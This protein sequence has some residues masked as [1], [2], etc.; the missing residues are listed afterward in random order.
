MPETS[1]ET[2]IIPDLLDVIEPV[3]AVIT[4]DAMGTQKEVERT[5]REHHAD[6][7]FALK[8]NHPTLLEDVTWAFTHADDL[9]WQGIEH[10]YVRTIEKG[11]GRLETRECRVVY[12]LGTLDPRWVAAWP[13]L[14][15]VARVRGH[16]EVNGAES[17]EDRYLLTSLPMNRGSTHGHWNTSYLMK[18]LNI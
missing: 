14:A 6:D 5:L 16:R 15:R 8:G 13:R 7:A 1:D 2:T 10:D 18:R 12:E 4:T 11:H 3:A 17:V 9:A